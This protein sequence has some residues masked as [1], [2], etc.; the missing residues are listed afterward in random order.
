MDR[1]GYDTTT[2]TKTAGVLWFK[3]CDVHT[4]CHIMEDLWKAYLEVC[5]MQRGAEV[6]YT[7]VR[8]RCRHFMFLAGYCAGKGFGFESP[9]VLIP[10]PDGEA[11]EEGEGVGYYHNLAASW[12]KIFSIYTGYTT[13]FLEN[14][15][16][17]IWVNIMWRYIFGDDGIIDFE[18][19]KF[20]ISRW[21][22]D[23]PFN[24]KR[25][26]GRATSREREAIEGLLRFY[27]GE[28]N[29]PSMTVP[30]VI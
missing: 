1:V 8:E 21:W 29:I 25:E 26:F 9:D 11:L 4:L 12:D 14:S 28:E 27:R 20:L 30:K 17:Q 18:D 3:N 22:N 15:T 10:R 16:D 13:S 23:P 24:P 6:Q 19:A 7:A 2:E 5:E